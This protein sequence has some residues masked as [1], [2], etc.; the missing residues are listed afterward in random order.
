MGGRER[1]RERN[2]AEKRERA[3]NRA[4]E[5]YFEGFGKRRGFLP[6]SP[7]TRF[8]TEPKDTERLV[9]HTPASDKRL[10]TGSP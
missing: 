2:R 5:R 10:L 7:E 8:E 4:R 3:R 9:N 6:F 1:E